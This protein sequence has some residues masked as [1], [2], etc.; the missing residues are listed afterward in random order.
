MWGLNLDRGAEGVGFKANEADVRLYFDD[1]TQIKKIIRGHQDQH[2]CC[3][4]IKSGSDAPV[5]WLRVAF[6]RT[7]TTAFTVGFNVER[8]LPNVITMS[9]A[10]EGRG[11]YSEGYGILTCNWSYP[12][13]TYR[14]YEN[15]VFQNDQARRVS[16]G[17][18]YVQPRLTPFR[19]NLT[20]PDDP[21]D[22]SKGVA[23]WWVDSSDDAGISEDLKR[24]ILDKTLE[25]ESP[26]EGA[27]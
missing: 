6:S 22:Q 23:H 10:A 4:L 18:V 14:I 17:Y 15:P 13:W 21:A 12:E 9:S 19:E 7:R 20:V 8:G 26:E 1:R 3:K 5:D 25:S 27:E 11:N 16:R 2:S 24:I